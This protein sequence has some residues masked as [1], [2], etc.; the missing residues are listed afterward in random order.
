MTV[1]PFLL[2]L[3]SQS[4]QS[5]NSCQAL[6]ASLNMIPDGPSH[7]LLYI[8]LN[9]PSHPSYI[10][11]LIGPPILTYIWPLTNLGNFL[12]YLFIFFN[13]KRINTYLQIKKFNINNLAF[14]LSIINLGIP[15]FSSWRHHTS[16]WRNQDGQASC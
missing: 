15:E 8:T 9:K 11:H 6:A 1:I 7:P 4:I 3:T 5:H 12:C 10:R 13:S 2:L 16:H 14:D